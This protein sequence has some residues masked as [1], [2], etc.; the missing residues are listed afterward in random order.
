MSADS[1]VIVSGEIGDERI[2]IGVTHLGLAK[3][4]HAGDEP[5]PWHGTQYLTVQLDI[6][7][8]ESQWHH[9]SLTNNALGRR[10]SG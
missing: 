10:I 7:A 5:D 3:E 8:G 6:Q 9:S 1:L 4:R 2:E